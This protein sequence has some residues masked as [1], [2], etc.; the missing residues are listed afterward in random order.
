MISETFCYHR[1]GAKRENLQRGPWFCCRLIWLPPPPH[2]VIWD[3]RQTRPCSD[4][5]R[6]I[7]EG[8]K[9]KS[10]IGLKH[11]NRRRLLFIPSIGWGMR[12]FITSDSLFTIKI[13]EMLVRGSEKRFSKYAAINKQNTF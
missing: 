6:A 13:A 11:K 10:D 1:D 12:Y 8:E 5:Y 7:A 9:S 2:P 3:R 4:K